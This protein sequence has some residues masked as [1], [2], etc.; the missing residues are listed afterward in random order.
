MLLHYYQSH[1]S[2]S[3]FTVQKPYKTL[4]MAVNGTLETLQ[5]HRLPL[6][7]SIDSSPSRISSLKVSQTLH[8]TFIATSTFSGSLHVLLADPV[9][10]LI[11]SEV[12]VSG[13]TLH[14]GSISCIDV[15]ENG[16][17][18]VSVGEDGR[19]NLVSVAAKWASLMEFAMG[20]LGFSLQWWDQKKPGG[21]TSQLKGNCILIAYF[22]SWV[23][24]CPSE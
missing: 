1:I 23:Q 4:A 3:Q 12:S 7:K 2:L 5:V 16:S 20:G 10:V 9:D 24:L 19:V 22:D 18:C 17:E 8:K 21:P 15:Q 11:E 6:S 13:K 14:V